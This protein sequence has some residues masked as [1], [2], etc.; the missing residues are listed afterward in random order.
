MDQ[1]AAAMKII[2]VVQFTQSNVN[3][4]PSQAWIHRRAW[5][6]QSVVLVRSIHMIQDNIVLVLT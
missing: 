5:K 6:L 4:Q 1:H 3:T 2:T